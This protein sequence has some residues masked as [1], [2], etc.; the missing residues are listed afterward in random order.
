MLGV[1]YNLRTSVTSAVMIQDRKGIR[2]RVT[3]IKERP[4]LV[5]NP[6]FLHLIA[7]Y[8]DFRISEDGHIAIEQRARALEGAIGHGSMFLH[9]C[10]GALSQLDLPSITRSSNLLATV[11]A[12]EE[13]RMKDYLLRH[14]WIMEFQSRVQ[15]AK[16]LDND[17]E[18]K[19]MAQEL[20]QHAD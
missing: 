1:T 16:G 17:T 15:D 2:D 7:A 18:R 3:R 4:D 13:T 20:R 9:E 6:S 8:Q 5:N 14:E 10:P 12:S 11:I 19:Q